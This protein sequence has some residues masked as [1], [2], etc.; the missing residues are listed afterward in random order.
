MQLNKPSWGIYVIANFLRCV[1]AKKIINY[2][3]N[4]RIMNEDKVD[5]V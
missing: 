2:L 4:V 3:A 5:T 1:A